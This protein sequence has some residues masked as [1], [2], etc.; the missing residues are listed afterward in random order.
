MIIDI[1][2]KV[3]NKKK[4]LLIDTEKKVWNKK[5]YKGP[6]SR[7]TTTEFFTLLDFD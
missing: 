6:S 4:Y 7:G 2:K 3:L 1:K 5:K